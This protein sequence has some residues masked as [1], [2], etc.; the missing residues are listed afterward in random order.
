[1]KNKN[2]KLFAIWGN[3][4][5]PKAG[6]MYKIDVIESIDGTEIPYGYIR[7]SQGVQYRGNLY[8]I[9]ERDNNWKLV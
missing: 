9:L 2:G 6:K 1:M 4:S 8:T 3:S 7:N 5:D